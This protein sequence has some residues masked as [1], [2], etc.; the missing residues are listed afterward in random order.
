MAEQDMR[1]MNSEDGE[2][3][4]KKSSSKGVGAH[5]KAASSAYIR[6]ST[7]MRNVL[8]VVVVVLA[9]L[10]VAI[11]VIGFRIFEAAR[12]TAVQQTLIT[13]VDATATEEEASDASPM[14]SKKIAVPD[15]VALLGHTQD[16]AV[17]ALEHG[18]QIT[19]TLEVNE[20][21]NPVKT[22]VQ[23]ALTEDPSDSRTGTPTVYLGL[24]AGGVI[25]RAGYSVATSSLGYGSLS[26]VDA[27]TNE[28]II[29]KTLEEAGLVVSEGSVQLPPDKMEY[30]T[31]DTDGT[32]LVKEY[33]AFSGS[34]MAGEAEHPWEAILAY[35]YSM[36]NATGNLNDTIRTVYI[37]IS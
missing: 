5:A 27:I 37:Y 7:R 8:I 6:K 34:G 15:L 24:D 14:V 32:T 22:D 1:N 23:V 21:G 33:Y 16:E 28:H 3:P 36:A 30:S 17:A 35:D 29:E 12:D 19:R 2:K 10:L 18:A 31:Y 20:E 26:F 25:I 11:G 9:V 13:G 4:K